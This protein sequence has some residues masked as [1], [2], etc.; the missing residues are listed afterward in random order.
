MRKKHGK[1]ARQKSNPLPELIGQICANNAGKSPEKRKLCKSPLKS[2]TVKKAKK[3]ASLS[4]KRNAHK[5]PKKFVKRLMKKT[6]SMSP[7]KFARR[8]LENNAGKN[9]CRSEFVYILPQFSLFFCAL[10]FHC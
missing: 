5:Y 9:Q 4:M 7:K 10:S 1:F 8:S 2:V 3:F 6:A